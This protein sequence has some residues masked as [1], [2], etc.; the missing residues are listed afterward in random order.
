MHKQF[1]YV[2]VIEF[3][4]PLI[5]L[6]LYK[7]VCEWPPTT[8]SISVTSRAICLSLVNPEWPRAIRM[9]TP[10]LSNRWASARIDVISS[11]NWIFPGFEI[12][13][14]I[15]KICSLEHFGF[16]HITFYMNSTVFN[17]KTLLANRK[18]LHANTVPNSLS[19]T[20]N[21]VV[22]CVCVCRTEYVHT[23]KW[24]KRASR[25][26]QPFKTYVP[27]FPLNS[28]LD[29][30]IIFFVVMMNVVGISNNVFLNFFFRV[31]MF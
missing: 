27:C 4:K 2:P 3:K 30:Y 11:R 22:L 21:N 8:R 9:F 5:Y 31:A 25:W 28:L 15:Y 10:S 26:L 29:L 20:V 6:P 19:L 18:R 16:T 12:S 14:N 23:V 17:T 24:R 13:C 1:I 7:N